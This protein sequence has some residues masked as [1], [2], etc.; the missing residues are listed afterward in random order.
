M[1]FCLHCG[2]PIPHAVMLKARW[3]PKFCSAE[4]RVADAALIKAARKE[5]R[6]ER[7]CCHACGH[8]LNAREQMQA[9]AIPVDT[10]D[11]RHCVCGH[12]CLLHYVE[13][14]DN[15]GEC[16]VGACDCKQYRVHQINDTEKRGREQVKCE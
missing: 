9:R 6:L 14:N 1:R 4:C 3:N 8:R 2:K 15:L 7:G 10:Q 12:S 13:A 16:I 11:E 5:H